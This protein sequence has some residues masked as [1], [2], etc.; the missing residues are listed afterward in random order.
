[1]SG[2]FDS[3]LTRLYE[4]Q[5]EKMFQV[6]Y[7]M[8]GSVE[9]AHDLVQDAFL[10]AL[11]QRDE[12]SQHPS[13]EGWL[14]ITMRNFALN[15]RRKGRRHPTVSL[16]DLIHIADRTPECPLDD[17][18]PKQLKPAERQ[19]LIWRFEDRLSHQEIADRLGISEA[20]CRSRVFR[21]VARCRQYLEP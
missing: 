7:R 20:A 12:L 9:T 5:Y 1:M 16:D 17:I 10:L 4:T 13:L 3:F 19:I 6:A 2:S 14:M 21:A 15:E 11:F 8:T 18:L